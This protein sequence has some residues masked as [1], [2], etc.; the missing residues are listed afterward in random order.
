MLSSTAAIGFS[1]TKSDGDVHL[2]SKPHFAILYRELF[3]VAPQW[4][5]IGLLLDLDRG[6]LNIIKTDEDDTHSRLEGMLSL[7]LKQIDL[8]PTK[9]QIITVLRELKLNEEA[10]RLKEKLT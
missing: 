4:K 8:P 2:K 7:W 6:E 9:S 10:Q 1:T 5:T 3:S